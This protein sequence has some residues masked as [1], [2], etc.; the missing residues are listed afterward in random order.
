MSAP[1][2]EVSH[3]T[4]EFQLGQVRSLKQTAID[5]FLTLRGEAVRERTP[6]R[7]LDDVDFQVAQGE[8]LGII[9]HNGAG[10]STLLKI[11]AGISNPSRGRVAVRGKVAPL[12]E[13]GA[14]LVPDL[15]GRENIFVNASILGM[16]RLEIKK[17]FDDIVAFSELEEFIDT[18]IKRYSS[19]MQVRLG[20]SIAT[21]IEAEILIVDE[22]LAVGDLAF[23]RRCFDRMERMIKGDGRT[24]L[25]VSHNIRQVERICKRALLLEHG[26]IERDGLPP[27]VCDELYR[28][29]E[30]LSRHTTESKFRGKRRQSSGEIELGDVRILGPDGNPVA[31]I[32][33]GGAVTIRASYT[34][35]A[36]LRQPVFGIG[37]HTPDFLYLATTYSDSQLNCD[38]IAPGAY[39]ISLSI[40]RFPFL[41][42]VYCVRVGVALGHLYSTA[43]YAENVASFQVVTSSVRWA[44]AMR[45]GFLPLDGT[46]RLEGAPGAEQL[47]DRNVQDSG[48]TIRC[49]RPGPRHG[50]LEVHH[51]LTR[52]H[53]CSRRHQGVLI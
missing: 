26:R 52:P 16:S 48:R 8:V 43:F 2:I 36:M 38:Q 53:H 4:K 14:G 46:W 25:L 31:E 3:V 47:D 28:R 32:P 50:F 40:P 45:D 11:I 21:S 19:G 24:V 1:I 42:G 49:G 29:S 23:Q 33:L 10:K 37:I 15:T 27:Q 13:V 44:E 5:A 17:K 35:H 41:P 39:E 34:V 51:S 12:I 20:F 30:R 9:G 6:F 22:V 18:P 7:A